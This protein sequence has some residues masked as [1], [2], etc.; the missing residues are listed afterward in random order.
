MAVNGQTQAL[1]ER[2]CSVYSLQR[3]LKACR[4][5]LESKELHNGLLQKKIVTL[6]GRLLSIQRNEV[7]WEKTVE[8]VREGVEEVW[9]EFAR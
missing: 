6:E 9:L 8:K 3:K 1:V 5:A 4:Q 7:E 2:Q